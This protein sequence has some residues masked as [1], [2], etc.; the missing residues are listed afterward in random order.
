MAT[1]PGDESH[2][3]GMDG[4]VLISLLRGV[5]QLEIIRGRF[6][7]WEPKDNSLLSG[8]KIMP[9]FLKELQGVWKQGKEYFASKGKWELV[10]APSDGKCGYFCRA[11]IANAPDMQDHLTWGSMFQGELLHQF[12]GYL[13]FGTWLEHDIFFL[14]LLETDARFATG[15]LWIRMIANGAAGPSYEGCTIQ[16]RAGHLRKGDVWLEGT[17]TSGDAM[18]AR[19]K[20]CNQ[21][22]ATRYCMHTHTRATR[23]H[24]H[25][26]T[27]DPTHSGLTL[28]VRHP[29]D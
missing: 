2:T 23:H 13:S 18:L 29:Y 8:G 28:Q 10:E 21:P 11:Y 12:Q 7:E 3:E 19:L 22:Y 24:M 5:K 4:T 15:V 1:Q 27:H 20:E 26:Y 25:T 14:D 17:V 9:I 16:I 6:N